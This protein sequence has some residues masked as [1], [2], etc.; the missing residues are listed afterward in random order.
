MGVLKGRIVRI[1]LANPR[2][3]EHIGRLHR[4]RV[5]VKI[6]ALPATY[7]KCRLVKGIL[8]PVAP[9]DR[10]LPEKPQS[11]INS[12][13]ANSLLPQELADI[14]A[15]RQRHEIAWHARLLISNEIEKEEVVAFKA[16][17]RQAIAN[18]A[19]T[20]SPPS[21]AR[22]LFNTRPNKGK[23]KGK[24]KGNEKSL[25]KKIVVATTRT[26]LSKTINPEMNNEVDLPNAPQTSDKTWAIV[27][28][29]GI[30]IMTI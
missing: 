16:Y 2:Y 10:L 18:F 6:S 13:I 24:G 23:G 25:A 19:A 11:R 3:A 8:K 21:P 27:A 20:D 22:V 5:K 1:F 15:T 12:D 17:L 7:S 29:K 30:V 4:H 26:V 28:R 14:I 9:S